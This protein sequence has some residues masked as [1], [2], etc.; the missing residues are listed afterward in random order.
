MLNLDKLG[1]I[2]MF[3]NEIFSPPLV[4][5][6]G[7][8]VAKLGGV[9]L[10]NSVSLHTTP[11]SRQSRASSPDKGSQGFVPLAKRATNPNL[12]ENLNL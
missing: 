5:G 8:C 10:I 7:F 12:M 4:R 9:V 3:N 6:G 2:G 1:F 11:Q